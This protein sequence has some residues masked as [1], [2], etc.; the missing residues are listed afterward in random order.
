MPTP[1]QKQPRKAR[2]TTPPASAPV[3]YAIS[4]STGNLA[5]HMLTAF[6]TQFPPGAL[7]VRFEAFVRSEARLEEVLEAALAARGVVCHAMVSPAFKARI[8]G[9]CAAAGIPCCDLTGGVV[10]FL[11]HQ[12]G[13]ATT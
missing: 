9:F 1:P 11:S 7:S 12:T 10:E 6:L 2:V 5:R 3:V 4:D 13:V 8:T